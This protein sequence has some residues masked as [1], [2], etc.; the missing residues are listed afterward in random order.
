MSIARYYECLDNHL[1]IYAMLLYFKEAEMKKYI[2]STNSVPTLH[3]VIDISEEG[4]PVAASVE[5]KEM[6]HPSVKREFKKS[7]DWLKYVNDMARSIYG[8]M[9]SRKFNITKAEPSKRSYTYY[10]RFQPADKNG[11][12]WDQELELQIELRDHVSQTHEGL[13]Q[14]TENLLVKSY[15][16]EGESYRTGWEVMKEIWKILDKLQQ[17]DFTSF[18]G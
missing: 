15:Y 14:V 1:L 7:D 4:A 3:I 8:S 12:L 11:D 10:I 6:H 18:I 17:G 16:I 13:G 5:F 9:I 2:H